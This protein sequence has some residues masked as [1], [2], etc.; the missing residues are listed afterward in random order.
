MKR[1]DFIALLAGY[2]L[3]S[4]SCIAH[5]IC[6]P[7]LVRLLDRGDKFVQ[8]RSGNAPRLGTYFIRWFGH[9]SFLIQSG[10]QT[11]VITDP[12]FNVIV[13]VVI[14][15]YGHC[16]GLDSGSNI[17]IRVCNDFGLAPGLD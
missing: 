4:F 6:N 15:A 7:S 17:E 3:I 2:L 10:S 8:I 12:N 9:S 1:R 13:G 5:A 14:V 16:I 11:K